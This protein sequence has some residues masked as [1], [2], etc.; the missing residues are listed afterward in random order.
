MKSEGCRGWMMVCPCDSPHAASVNILV[1]E[2]L[3]K[4][5]ARITKECV[6]PL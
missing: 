1:R 3:Q 2:S 4:E 5:D 6:F